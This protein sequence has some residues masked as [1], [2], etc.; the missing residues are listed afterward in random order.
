[1][2]SIFKMV[3]AL[4]VTMLVL[5]AFPM[6]VNAYHYRP[7][8]RAEYIKDVT[9]P[10]GFKVAPGETFTKTWQVRNIGTCTWTKDVYEL[11]FSTG[12]NFGIT[13]PVKLKEDVLPYGVA[14]ISIEN[15][16]APSNSG[17]HYSHWKLSNGSGETF[18]VGRWGN[19]ALFAKINVVVPPTV[20]YEFATDANANSA[21]WTSGSGTPPT[22]PSMPGSPDGSAI[23]DSTFKFESNV[24]ATPGLL[25]TPDNS[26]HGFIKA[27]YPPYLVNRGDRFQATVGC[28]V[29]ATSC[30]V[31]FKLKYRIGA[32]REYTL[33]TYPERHEGLTRRVDINL[34]SLAGK[35]VSFIL[36][37]SAYRNPFGDSAIWG[38]P[39]IV[40]TGTSSGVS[41]VGWSSNDMGDFTFEFPSNSVVSNVDKVTL[42]IIPGTNLNEK[43]VEVSTKTLAAAGDE[44]LSSNPGPSAPT[45]VTFNG[46]EFMKETGGDG[47]AGSF[48]EWVSYS[49][50]H[51]S[52]PLTCVSL[53]FILS[54]SNA[55]NFDPPRPE[56]NQA[57]ESVVFDLIM[58]RFKWVE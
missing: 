18:G 27:E 46:V 15:M 29:S 22:F 50:V 16:V 36:Y 8:N 38:N 4:L 17:I 33:G 34:N 25:V 37:V 12:E 35:N 9:V 53:T 5:A 40:G 3:S 54:Y 44:C 14:N 32:G 55:G 58:G 56:F 42:P 48:V 39:V 47:G 10:D 24:T 45:P 11:V 26:Y 30:Y 49:A 7:C 52:K 19:V 23:V 31:I 43:Y 21:I 51:P 1:M 57:A 6:G 28:E 41:P 2:K 13:T 20:T